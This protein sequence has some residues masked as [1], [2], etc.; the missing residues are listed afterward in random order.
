MAATSSGCARSSDSGTLNAWSLIVTPRAFACTPFA[1]APLLT[2]TKT[3][4]G[5]LNVGGTVTYTV[6]LTKPLVNRPGAP[7]LLFLP[8]VLPVLRTM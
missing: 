3:V 8:P 6:T 7:S 2:A 5:T 1:G 4:S